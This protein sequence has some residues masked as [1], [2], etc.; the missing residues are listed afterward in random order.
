MS[1]ATARWILT[2]AM[3]CFIP[4]FS[5]SLSHVGG[6][7]LRHGS[8]VATILAI[9]SFGIMACVLSVSL[10]H[11]AWA[12]A[13]ITRSPKWASWLLAI[14]FDLALVVGELT[15]VFASDAGVKVCVYAIMGTV[16]LLSMLLNCWAFMGHPK[17]LARAAHKTSERKAPT[18]KPR[19]KVAQ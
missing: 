6:E 3:G 18:R 5:L 14:A 13:D 17:A 2:L 19:L 15:Q 7:L 12:V 9:G 11:L 4:L 1:T 16:C 8:T 10:S